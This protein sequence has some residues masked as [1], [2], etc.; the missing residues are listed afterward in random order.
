MKYFLTVERTYRVGLEFEATNE[1]E[2]EMMAVE[3]SSN[4]GDEIFDGYC[5]S[6]YALC[7]ESGRTIVDWS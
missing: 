5:D 6:D 2:A 1:N 3:L 4:V 7:D